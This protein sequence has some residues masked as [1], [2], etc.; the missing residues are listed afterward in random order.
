MLCIIRRL[1]AFHSDSLSEFFLGLFYIAKIELLITIEVG[2]FYGFACQIRVSLLPLDNIQVI[3]KIVPWDALFK[4]PANNCRKLLLGNSWNYSNQTFVFLQLGVDVRQTA[5]RNFSL[6]VLVKWFKYC[7]D[8]I[9]FPFRYTA[10]GIL[11][12]PLWKFLL[13]SCLRHFVWVVDNLPTSSCQLL[14]LDS[15]LLC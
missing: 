14:L 7:F 8:F 10:Q 3:P 5:H 2:I 11:L 15:F 12:L 6:F 4:V 13:D 1:L 9:F